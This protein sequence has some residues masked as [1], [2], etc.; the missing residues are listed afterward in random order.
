MKKYITVLVMALVML[1][2]LPGCFLVGGGEEELPEVPAATPASI[3]ALQ[4]EIN[5]LKTQV[6]SLSSQLASVS[7][8]PTDTSAI[9]ASIAVLQT[10]IAD[11]TARL[12]TLEA[13][14]TGDTGDDTDGGSSTSSGTWDTIRWHLRDVEMTYKTITACNVS[15]PL[16]CTPNQVQLDN[17]EDEIYADVHTSPRNIED[18]DLY[19]VELVVSSGHEGWDV[20]LEDVVFVLILSADGYAM[21]DEEATYLDSDRT[22]YLLWETDFTIREREGRD[23]TR[24]VTFESDE[25][26]KLE[27]EANDYETLDLVLEL[28]YA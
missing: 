24:R 16:N 2:V 23:V 3:P 13:A 17:I 20:T 15:T 1:L 11:L 28:Y 9:E 19:D 4:S 22:P 12:A 18:E 26:A 6:S 14:D 10:Q 21:L 8:S 7:V 5:S 27:I 25:L